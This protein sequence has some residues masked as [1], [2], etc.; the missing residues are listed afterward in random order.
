MKRI[1]LL[2]LLMFSISQLNYAIPSASAIENIINKIN[3][4]ANTNGNLLVQAD[5]L[6]NQKKYEEA[7][8]LFQRV[9]ESD[10]DGQ[11]LIFKKI[12]L[13]YAAL[14][15]NVS[16]VRYIE[17]SL[18][19]V[20]DLTI[21]NDSGFKTIRDAPQFI[22]LKDKYSP[23]FTIWS[24]LYMYVALIGLYTIIVI[25]FNKRID[26]SARFL[27]SG[28]I[29][30]HSTFI[31]NLCFN[32]TNIQYI[33]PHSYLMSTGF[34]FL[35]GPLLYFYLK[36]TTTHYK[37]KRKDLI[38]LL[39]TLLFLIYILPIYLMSAQD[40]LNLMLGRSADGQIAT[41]SAYLQL[42]VVLKLAS[43]VIYGFYSHKLYLASKRT[44]QLP[45]STSLWQ[46]NI[47]A[48]HLTY[49]VSYAIYGLVISNEIA[50]GFLYHSQII[51][52]S[53][54]V[55]FLGFSSNLQ[56]DVLS[57]IISLKNH[58]YFK[59]EKSGL[60]HSL[61]KELKENLLNLFDIEKIYRENDINLESLAKRLN[62]TRHNASQIINEHFNMNFHE[63][64]NKYRIQEAKFILESDYKKSLH[65]ID[66]AYEV[67]FNNKV[68]F[69]KAFKKETHLT[70]SQ[71]QNNSFKS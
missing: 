19:E 22:N 39:P 63:F 18:F 3:L 15:D 33:F 36:R 16:A 28:F 62:T 42:I 4:T 71:Y 40:K 20:F 6:L 27:L 41:D 64:I 59:Y 52:M 32:I 49:V 13:A 65:I 45:K 23:N 37:F 53:A 34:S 50:S 51:C 1:T 29:L 11:A 14:G 25:F 7:I 67:G 47:Y 54:M 43:L 68:T 38:H 12:S 57:G 10:S 66:I 44:Q 5:L 9:L 21:L 58:L 48:I 17:K 55:L 69:N 8:S 70:P 31:L 60:T 30:I 61:S 46:R 26:N 2:L 56:P 24:F 35:Y